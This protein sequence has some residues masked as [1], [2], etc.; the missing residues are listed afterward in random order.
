MF[1]TLSLISSNSELH[2]CVGN[3]K[4]YIYKIYIKDTKYAKYTVNTIWIYQIK[5]IYIY[6]YV[7]NYVVWEME[8]GRVKIL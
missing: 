6:I 5:Y 4:K 1:L 7:Y 3:D 2:N 8:K